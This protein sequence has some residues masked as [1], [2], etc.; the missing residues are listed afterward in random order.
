MIAF[1][2]GPLLWFSCVFFAAGCLVRLALPYVHSTPGRLVRKAREKHEADV[3]R[4][5][6]SKRN[7]EASFD[8]VPLPLP[9][10]GL[11][12]LVLGGPL[13]YQGHAELISLRWQVAWPALPHFYSDIL[14]VAA[15]AVTVL[16]ALGIVEL[17]NNSG[18]RRTVVF[19]LMLLCAL[20]FFTGLMARYRMPGYDIWILAH[21]L[22]GE[23]LL[24]AI[25]CTGLF[26]IVFFFIP[27]R[28]LKKT[29]DAV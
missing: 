14:A 6:C 4:A 16:A 17:P 29:E 26:S 20:P 10:W 27:S 21:I 25:P 3:W 5:P 7:R 15:L 13:F 8:P 12:L 18:S 1:I 24:L 28:C 11:V 9:T 19:G 22:L 23:L 2:T